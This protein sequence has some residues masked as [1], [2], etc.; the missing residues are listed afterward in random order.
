MFKRMKKK[1]GYQWLWTRYH[2]YLHQE[3]RASDTCLLVSYTDS[4]LPFSLK[5][6]YCQE[7]FICENWEFIRTVK[8]KIGWCSFYFLSMLLKPGRP[9]QWKT[10]LVQFRIPPSHKLKEEKKNVLRKFKHNNLE[11]NFFVFSLE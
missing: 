4:L 3:L 5:G 7:K 11:Y 1:P 2:R 9:V 10:G 6:F 8:V